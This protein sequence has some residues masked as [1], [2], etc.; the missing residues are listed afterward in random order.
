MTHRKTHRKLNLHTLALW[1]ALPMART[2]QV[3][4]RLHMILKPN[5]SRRALTRRA[6]FISLVAAAL[7]VGTLA[8]LRPAAQAEAAPA[9]KQNSAPRKHP[10]SK[11]T[12][13]VSAVQAVPG[14]FDAMT[15]VSEGRSL[16]PQAATEQEKILTAHPDDYAAHIQLL[17]YYGRKQFGLPHSLAGPYEQQ[18]FWFVQNHP[19]SVLCGQP[20]TWLLKR[21]N[22]EGFEQGKALWLKQVAAHPANTII[23]GK[24]ADFCHLSDNMTAERLLQQAQALEPKNPEW[25]QQIGDLYALQSQPPRWRKPVLSPE[26]QQA[27]AQISLVEYETASHLA[28][29]SAMANSLLRDCAVM[30]YA[31]GNYDKARGYAN[32]LLTVG[33]QF[34]QSASKDYFNQGDTATYYANLI[35]GRLALRDGN[36]AQA[37]AHLQMM[38]RLYSVS[39]KSAFG[40]NM[41]LARDLLAAGRQDAVL[42]YFDECAKFWK[43]P[44]LKTWRAE[45]QAGKTP[46]FGANLS[47]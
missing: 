35:L 15:L 7:G 1:A 34:A 20:D 12:A 43:N 18:V 21:Y 31:A 3:E 40:P 41:S 45:V 23:L 9:T 30:A 27:L 14:E 37:E 28:T 13:R 38:G 39:V 47:Y 33:Q 6:T 5:T 24:A 10:M 19:E 32:D 11:A 16:T 2:A 44:R 17:G 26:K 8:A 25:P 46:D 22:S 4:S 36:T 42:A 29:N